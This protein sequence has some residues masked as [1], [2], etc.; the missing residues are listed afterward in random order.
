MW[1]PNEAK[2]ASRQDGPESAVATSTDPAMELGT[3]IQVPLRLKRHLGK[4]HLEERFEVN[5][6]RQ[7]DRP[8]IPQRCQQLFD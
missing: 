3:S 5:H 4:F 7:P 6:L 8:I 2:P 1:D